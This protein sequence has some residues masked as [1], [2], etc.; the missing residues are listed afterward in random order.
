MEDFN[1][2]IATT[3]GT[4]LFAKVEIQT[5]LKNVGDSKATANKTSIT[6][7]VVAKT[8]LN[9]IEV[10]QR[11]RSLLKEKPEIFR[12]TLKVVPLEKVVSSNIEEMKRA[13]KEML[14]EIGQTETFRITVNKRHSNLS[15]NEVVKEV[16][17]LIDRKV[18]LDNPD[19]IVLIEILGSLT[20]ISVIKSGDVLSVVK[21]RFSS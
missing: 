6:G 18:K 10:I 15:T 7:L 8:T 5:L 17:N 21:E 20:G 14:S 2:L 1:L 11:L 9:P 12:Y 16:A 13:C 3:R 4:E 19:K